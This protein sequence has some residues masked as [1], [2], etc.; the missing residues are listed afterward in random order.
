MTENNWTISCFQM[1]SEGF[2]SFRL[3]GMNKYIQYDLIV[4]LNEDL[5]DK[6]VVTVRL[7]PFPVQTK[8]DNVLN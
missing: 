8:E 7:W 2:L 3:M 1:T 4:A 5:E 6:Q